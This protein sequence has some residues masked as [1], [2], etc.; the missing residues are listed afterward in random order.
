[1]NQEIFK[2]DVADK[3]QF[4]AKT[5]IVWGVWEYTDPNTGELY[6]GTY[7]SEGEFTC[8]NWEHAEPTEYEDEL[9]IEIFNELEVSV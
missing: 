3:V 9:L 7:S 2:I 8:D 5:R 1:M 6:T 4:T